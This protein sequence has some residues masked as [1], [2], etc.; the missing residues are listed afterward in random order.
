M[1]TRKYLLISIIPVLFGIILFYWFYFRVEEKAFNLVIDVKRSALEQISN[2]VITQF[3]LI[4]FDLTN[5]SNRNS[6][7]KLNSEGKKEIDDYYLTHSSI[8]VTISRVD[9]DGYI[10][11]SAPNIESVGHFVGNQTHNK[12]AVEQKIPVI[13]DVF[14][15]VQGFKAIAYAYPIFKDGRFDGTISA[16][17]PITKLGE[18]LLK[19]SDLKSFG[20]SFFVTENGI[21]IYCTLDSTHIGKE[22]YRSNE[23][24]DKYKSI[25][26]R[27][28]NKEI[29]TARYMGFSQRD[30][31]KR[32]I[33]WI[34]FRPIVLENTFWSVGL[35]TTEKEFLGEIREF[36]TSFLIIILIS[37]IIFIGLIVVYL[38]SS[39]KAENAL[40]RRDQK[41]RVVTE[42]SGQIVYEYDLQ[43]Q[44]IE[45]SGAVNEMLGFAYEEFREFDVKK[46]MGLLHPDDLQ[47]FKIN[48]AKIFS[49]KNNYTHS[50]RIRKPN[51]EYI[52]VEDSGL[53]VR[54]AKTHKLKCMG[55]LKNI[56]QRKNA[57]S[58]LLNYKDHLEAT[59]ISRTKELELLNERLKDDIKKR[60]KT[61]QELLLAIE[62]AE[63]SDKLK[64]EFLAQVSHEIRSPIN[65]I[66]S[67]SNLIKSELSDKVDDELKEGFNIIST[68]G[69]RITRTIDLILNM[70]EIQTNSYTPQFTQFD[71]IGDVLSPIVR[72]F[73]IQAGIKS[74]SIEL[75]DKI[76]G[77][78][79]LINRDRYS[80]GQIF[81]NLID[82]A[83]KYTCE[84]GITVTANKLIDDKIS[85]SVIDSGIGISEDYMRNLFSPFSQEEQGYSRK[86]DGTGLGLALVKKY[87]EINNSEIEV[88][89]K[90]GE[91]TEMRI[92]FN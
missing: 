26:K 85:I 89:S 15:A 57:E 88:I 80:V 36:R 62:K 55:T 69:T 64:S 90:K 4:K 7:I 1:K 84:G 65:S 58:E 6:I 12:I 72:D 66:L 40:L 76:T 70:S 68:S 14:D 3:K 52:Y 27:M 77:S 17:I 83:I 16:L 24:L 47:E 44:K 38:Y 63:T 30:D 42:Q 37:F 79:S 91:G 5:L 11:Y 13:S 48:T 46:W 43:T 34:T 21:E 87:C 92:T 19:S 45:W 29:G 23:G 49:E 9:K 67:F 61:E 86:Y 59:V 22:I 18:L 53:F 8:F 60:E 50:Y 56:T 25:T 31:S 33:K 39:R 28:M 75:I 20:H 78:G 71:L 81:I 35:V 10:T 73:K 41:Y 82:N 2:S 54:V 51:N 74:L 32:T